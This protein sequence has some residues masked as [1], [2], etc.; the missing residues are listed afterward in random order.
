[1]LDPFVKAH[2]VE[3]NANGQID[4]VAGIITT[5]AVEFDCAIDAPHHVAKGTADPG[6]A[7]RGRGASAFKDAARLVYTLT[8]MSRDEAEA[9]GVT[10]YQR[11]QLVRLDSAK[12]NI[13]PPAAEAKW[14]EII[15][16]DLGNGNET[17]PH[18]DEVQTVRLWTPP[19]LWAGLTTFVINEILNQIDKG[20]PDGRRYSHH[21]SANERAAW[22]VVAHFAPDKNRRQARQI[23][24]TWVAN[25]LLQVESYENPS[26]RKPE[27]GLKVNYAKRP[28]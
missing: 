8:P 17:Y 20:M 19:S 6:N 25:D 7:D 26:R 15:G 3:E 9:F 27:N 4:T 24:D 10:E 16:V 21:G 28:G 5:I 2:G 14:F 11:R 22:K 18:G 13:A 23:I 1:M 12:V